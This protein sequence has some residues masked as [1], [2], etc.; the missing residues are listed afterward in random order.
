MDIGSLF[1]QVGDFR[2]NLRTNGR[3]DG[4][5]LKRKVVELAKSYRM[6]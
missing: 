4:N 6:V 2:V 3:S 1:R 5:K